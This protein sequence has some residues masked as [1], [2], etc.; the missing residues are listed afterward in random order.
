M[1]AQMPNVPETLPVSD[2]DR[3]E[4]LLKTKNPWETAEDVEH[5]L[6]TA[7]LS[8][9]EFQKQLLRH[10]INQP[11]LVGLPDRRPPITTIPSPLEDSDIIRQLVYEKFP[12]MSKEMVEHQLLVMGMNGMDTEDQID[13]IL[14]GP[15]PAPFE[16]PS[17][18]ESSPPATFGFGGGYRSG[19][20]SNTTTPDS[21][22]R[23]STVGSMASDEGLGGGY[24][25]QGSSNTTTPDSSRRPSTTGSSMI[26]DEEYYNDP[27]YNSLANALDMSILRRGTKRPRVDEE[28]V[29][30]KRVRIDDSVV[31]NSGKSDHVFKRPNTSILRPNK[32]PPP[33]DT[34]PTSA[35]FPPVNYKELSSGESTPASSGTSSDE[36]RERKNA[37]A[38]ARYAKRKANGTLKK[39]VKK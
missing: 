14:M 9:S 15:A 24:R 37:M 36:E 23:P 13:R 8:G 4:V 16:Y 31:T 25:S 26:G 29:V 3:I 39:R 12:S 28:E 1:I 10:L 33:I 20:S 38:R 35:R 30:N 27:T 32:K 7:R 34:R 6:E 5:I 22:R 11:N 18:D 2:L 21:S 19:G 17:P